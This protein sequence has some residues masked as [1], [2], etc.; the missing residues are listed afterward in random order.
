MKD[1]LI[2][3]NTQPAPHKQLVRRAATWSHW[4]EAPKSFIQPPLITKS[5]DVRSNLNSQNTPREVL[6]NPTPFADSLFLWLRSWDRRALEPRQL[7]PWACNTSL[8]QG[9]VHAASPVPFQPAASAPSWPGAQQGLQPAVQKC[10]TQAPRFV[11]AAWIWVWVFTQTL[12]RWTFCWF[13]SPKAVRGSEVLAVAYY[14]A[15]PAQT[16]GLGHNSKKWEEFRE[17]RLA[18]AIFW[19]FL[20]SP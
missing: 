9:D 12:Q 6:K 11:W 19:A 10:E 14:G 7:F 17:D 5:G 3:K 18:S 15:N 2:S 13:S 20:F 16:F 4:E 8:G 1:F